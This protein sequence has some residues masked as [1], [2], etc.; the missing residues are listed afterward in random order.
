MKLAKIH[1][2]A[3]S[4]FTKILDNSSFFL[5]YQKQWVFSHWT[6]SLNIY[7]VLTLSSR[8]VQCFHIQ[9]PVH[10]LMMPTFKWVAFG[11]L[12]C[13]FNPYTVDDLK[14]KMMSNLNIKYAFIWYTQ[15]P[16]FIQM[17]ILWELPFASIPNRTLDPKQTKT[18]ISEQVYYFN[19][20]VL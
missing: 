7:R 11:D 13:I 12:W 3:K 16:K 2:H 17:L 5:S 1:L 20:K 19:P 18:L 9:T 6:S 15:R 10:Q 14:D 8:N 4:C